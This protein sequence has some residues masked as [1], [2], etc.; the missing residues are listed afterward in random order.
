MRHSSLSITVLAAALLIAGCGGGK[1]AAP[2]NASGGPGG[3]GSSTEP[4]GPATTV[5][6]ATAGT[7]SGKVTFDGAAPAEKTISVEGDPYCAGKHADGVKTE[8]AVVSSTGEVANVFVW[9]KKG[10]TGSFPAPSTPVVLDQNGCRY[11]PHVLGMQAGQEIIIRNSDETMHN[12]H[13]LPKLNG[14]FNFAQTK[15][16]DESRKKFDVQEVMVKFKCDAHG[17]MNAYIG[18]VKH[19][20]F[21]VTGADGAFELKNVPPGEYEVEAWHEK[22]GVQ[23]FKLKLDAKGK[24]TA[25]FVFKAN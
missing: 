21:Q 7:I 2:T 16:G 14:D 17:W 9:I 11:L 15:K 12:V 10:I 25:N 3:N 20:Y 23:Q 8:S 22:F 18:V 24:G 19:P 1:P 5:D 4:A 6:T 13:S